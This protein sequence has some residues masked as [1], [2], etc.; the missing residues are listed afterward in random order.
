MGHFNSVSVISW[1]IVLLVE[2]IE[3]PRKTTDLLHLF[4][5][6]DHVKWHTFATDR[7]QTCGNT[8]V[9]LISFVDVNPYNK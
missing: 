6:L 8:N 2:E 7:N 4:D 9:G 1:L 3:V 5:E